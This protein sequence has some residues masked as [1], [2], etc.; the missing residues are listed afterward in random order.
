MARPSRSIWLVLV[1]VLLLSQLW[2]ELLAVSHNSIVKVLPGLQGPLPFELETGYVGVG[3]SEEVQLFYYFLKSERNPEED[4][5]MLWLTGGPG[6]SA[7]TALFFEIGPL[8][9]KVE[10]YNGSLPTLVL[11]P[12]SWTKVSSIIFIDSPVGTGFSYART[13]F[14]SQPGDL[15]QVQHALQLFR[16]WLVDHP[17]FMSNPVYIGGDSYS[18]IPV[19]VLAE[20]ISNGNEAGLHTREPSNSATRR[21]QF[22]NPICS[23]NGTYF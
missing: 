19:P 16:K 12:H 5:L 7:V 10:Q 4:P 15:E 20:E 17:S 13:S 9:F 2:F 3:E 23:W 11:N 6:C 18:G 1:Q 14:A 22:R 8:N 21:T